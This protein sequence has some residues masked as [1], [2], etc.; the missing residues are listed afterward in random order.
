MART[1]TNVATAP[2]SPLGEPPVVEP[3]VE[4]L[5]E[6]DATPEVERPDGN[7]ADD[8]EWLYDQV[9]HKLGCPMI[10]APFQG[11]DTE[12]G[13]GQRM[14]RF[15]LTEPRRQDN[16]MPRTYRIIRCI[17][18]GNGARIKLPRDD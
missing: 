1:R 6:G 16:P 3:I 11:T 18:C 8:T 5:S 4:Q 15:D 17:E 13:R 7:I 2:N 14:E 9:Q 10:D 12:P